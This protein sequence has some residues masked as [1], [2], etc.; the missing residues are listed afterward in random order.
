MPGVT[1]DRVSVP[2]QVGG[3]WCELVDTGGYGFDDAQGLTDHIKHQIELAMARADLVLFVVDAHAGLTEVDKTI[4]KLLRDQGIKT[5]ILANKTDGP[6]YEQGLGDFARLGLG[7][8]TGV[9]ATTGHNLKILPEI[10]EKHV[11]LSDAPAEIPE[12]EMS[13]AI[14]GKRNAGKSTLVNAIATLFG[15]AEDRVIVSEIPRHD[16]G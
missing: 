11:D 14:V 8:P 15:Q 2:Y 6:K 4:A 5:A 10:I 12:P 16:A 7:T 1:R 9:S 3:K 13:V